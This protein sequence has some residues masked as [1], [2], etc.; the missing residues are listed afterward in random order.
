MSTKKIQ[1]VGS[2]G[3]EVDSTLTQ[4]G[5][6]ADA[7]VTGDAINVLN[8]LVG[9]TSVSSQISTAMDDLADVAETGSWNDLLDKPAELTNEEIDEICGMGVISSEDDFV[10]ETTGVSYRLYVNNGK[11][12]MREAE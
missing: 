3:A 9:D 5:F 10:D 6:A 1:L 8:T 11:L 12:H 2:L 4:S 7:K